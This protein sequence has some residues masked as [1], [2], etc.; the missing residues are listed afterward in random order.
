MKVTN[1]SIAEIIN[2]SF[3]FV[4]KTKTINLKKYGFLKNK[5]VSS[6]SVSD[7]KNFKGMDPN[8]QKVGTK[9]AMGTVGG[10]AVG[11]LLTGGVGAIV[12]GMAGGNTIKTF[13]TTDI[14]L[15]FNDGNWVVVHFDNT[16]N[17]DVVG[18][19]NNVII[20]ALKQELA[21]KATN[22]FG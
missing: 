13:S 21:Q 17:E 9:G 6:Y 2:G 16:N 14:A 10:A 3:E 7:V 12:G 20:D 1:S 4:G 22:P 11:G 5:T 18:R 19:L 8:V 15:E